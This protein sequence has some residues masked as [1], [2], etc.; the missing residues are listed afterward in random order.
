M[1][2]LLGTL[3]PGER[4]YVT[5][6]GLDYTF[7]VEAQSPGGTR[8]R[9]TRRRDIDFTVKDDEG[10]T[11][12]VKFVKRPT[13]IVV[14]AGTEVTRLPTDPNES[15]PVTPRAKTHVSARKTPAGKARTDY[16]LDQQILESA[17]PTA[18]TRKTVVIAAPPVKVQKAKAPKRRKAKKQ[19]N[20]SRSRKERARASVEG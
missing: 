4:G 20:T 12:E 15:A 19:K 6:L 2:T 8:I 17:L 13:A 3:E 18:D 16:D 14:S 11:Q 7:V 10:Q 9:Y 1:S 5:G